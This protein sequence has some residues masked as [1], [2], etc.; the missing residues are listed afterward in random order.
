MAK[1]FLSL[2][3]ATLRRRFDRKEMAADLRRA[4]RDLSGRERPDDA[5]ISV[6]AGYL[7]LAA[8][9]IE[10]KVK[11]AR[12][13]KPAAAGS[14]EWWRRQFWASEIRRTARAVDRARRMGRHLKGDR[15][16]IALERVAGRSG[17]PEGTLKD[18]HQQ[19][20]GGRS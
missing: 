15:F 1:N 18:W 16:A 11:A 5:L 12:G 9:A 6:P 8:A 2:R 19:F 3:A 10:G 13:A 7:R 4:C 17:I 20:W 14:A